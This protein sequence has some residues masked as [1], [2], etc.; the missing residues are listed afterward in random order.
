MSN[1]DDYTHKHPCAHATE[2]CHAHAAGYALARSRRAF[3]WTAWPLALGAFLAF[4]PTS[5][6]RE[7]APNW[8]A[9]VGLLTCGALVL[10]YALFC[11]F[12]IAHEARVSPEGWDSRQQERCV[13]DGAE[14]AAKTQALYGA[15]YQESQLDAS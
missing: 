11:E 4:A 7:G 15:P 1:G 12:P 5:T 2:F 8:L 14:Q 10:R 9:E 13:R 6:R 3:F